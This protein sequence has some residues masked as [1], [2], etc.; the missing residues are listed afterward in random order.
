MLTYVVHSNNY[1]YTTFS[2]AFGEIAQPEQV[3]K[4]WFEAWQVNLHH[5]VTLGLA[6]KAETRATDFSMAINFCVSALLANRSVV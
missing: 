6:L 3:V 2:S 5:L 4:K 1:F